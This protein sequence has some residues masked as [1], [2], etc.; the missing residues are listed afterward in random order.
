MKNKSN[1][2]S[3]WDNF[4]YSEPKPEIKTIVTGTKAARFKWFLAGI[5]VAT[6]AIKFIF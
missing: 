6:I 2:Y 4:I 3:M 5:A 1:Y